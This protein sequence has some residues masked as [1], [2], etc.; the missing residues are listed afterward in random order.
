MKS[1]ES[2]D[3]LKHPAASSFVQPLFRVRVQRGQRLRVRIFLSTVSISSC[4][5]RFYPASFSLDVKGLPEASYEDE[6]S[7][8]P[9]QQS[10]ASSSLCFYQAFSLPIIN[11][12]AS[13]I[14]YELF[15]TPQTRCSL[16]WSLI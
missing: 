1:E 11:H 4:S 7:R 2:P 3:S 16:V 13:V 15:T 8:E 9:T 6:D 14:S 10:W 12:A 5:L